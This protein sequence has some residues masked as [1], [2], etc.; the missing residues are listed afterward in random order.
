MLS[1]HTGPGM[2]DVQ[3]E[4]L[5]RDTGH[6][7]GPVDQVSSLACCI[8][9]H[10]YNSKGCSRLTLYAY[11]CWELVPALPG[12]YTPGNIDCEQISEY[13]F[14]VLS[15]QYDVSSVAQRTG[16]SAAKSVSLEASHLHWILRC[17]GDRRP[18]HFR[19]IALGS[20]KSSS[21]S[22]SHWCLLLPAPRAPQTNWTQGVPAS[23]AS[24]R[25]GG[26]IRNYRHVLQPRQ[27][28]NR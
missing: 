16:I 6:S 28:F 21:V 18:V 14:I 12:L 7:K 22:S 8:I 23:A 24:M 11:A 9:A 17:G 2:F 19:L 25:L 3:G 10:V 20:C 5:E 13:L 15:C 4:G 27:L 26:L 1:L